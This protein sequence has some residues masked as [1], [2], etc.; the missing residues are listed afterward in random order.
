MKTSFSITITFLVVG[1]VFILTSIP[2]QLGKIPPNSFYGIRIPKAFQ[3]TELWYK[4]NAVGGGILIAYGA[5]SL[6]VGIALYF[7][8][9]RANLDFN[10]SM[11]GLFALIG[12]S[13]VHVMLACNGIR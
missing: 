13:F 6:V 8:S 10:A 1:L 9:A 4:V 2:L 7:I 12:V 11:I 5:V 3:S